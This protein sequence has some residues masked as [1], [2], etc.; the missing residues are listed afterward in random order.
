MKI[1]ALIALLLPL[2]AW[3]YCNDP[4]DRLPSCLDIFLSEGFKDN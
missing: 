1:V 3:S 2:N 4:G